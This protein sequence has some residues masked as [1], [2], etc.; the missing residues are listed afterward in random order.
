MMI[1]LVDVGFRF[2]F[3]YTNRDTVFGAAPFAQFLRWY[4][5]SWKALLHSWKF[6]VLKDQFANTILQIQFSFSFEDTFTQQDVVRKILT[7]VR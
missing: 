4:I 3:P 5:S 1:N 6:A 2:F 7:F